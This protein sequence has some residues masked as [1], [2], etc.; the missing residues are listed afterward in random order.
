MLNEC[1][2]EFKD[3]NI[4]NDYSEDELFELFCGI[5]VTKESDT[6]FSEVESAIV[7]GG[8]DGGIDTFAI[9]VNDRIIANEDD[10]S[11][12]K[13]NEKT[14]VSITIIQSKTT[15]SFSESVLDKLYITLPLVFDLNIDESKLLERLNPSVVEKIIA[16]RQVWFSSIKKRSSISFVFCYACKAEIIVINDAFKSK[17]KQ[18]LDL[19]H[20]K[21]SVATADFKLL[22]SKELIELYNYKK[23]AEIELRFK[24]GPLPIP[25]IGKD[26]GYVGAVSLKDFHEFITSERG[27]IREEIFE[28]NIRYYQGEVDVNK[29]IAQTLIEDNVNDFWW[30]NNGIT[31]LCD[32]AQS[33]PKILQITNPQVV[34][35]LQ[36]SFSIFNNKD[37][38]EN[39][40]KKSVLV[41]IILSKERET[42]DK[43]IEATNS[44]NQVP[45]VLLRAT[46]DIQRM[47]EKYFS[48]EEYYYDRRKNYYKNQGKPITRVFT[49]QD[50]AQ[51]I[52]AILNKNP[53]T[54]RKNPTTIIKSDESY[55]RIFSDSYDF[56]LFLN[57]ALIVRSVKLYISALND[58]EIDKNLMKN[59]SFHISL[60]LAS[61]K[62]GKGLFGEDD[63]TQFDKE[64][65][66]E[67]IDK[68][69]KRFLKYFDSYQS[70]MKENPINIAKSSMFDK[71]LIQCIKQDTY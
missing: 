47:I 69:L 29:K 39:S 44:Q 20:E 36:T 22:S 30:L 42:V 11:E 10:V 51:A 50:V 64:N 45:A 1:L 66:P 13:F 43:I 59:F 4:L 8:L 3:Q 46:D 57:A 33:L 37:R 63:I 24:E 71:E 26:Y 28:N 53:S 68:A 41:K 14:K 25:Y 32:T 61:L 55:G 56:K 6:D 58:A 17:Q 67:I 12:I 21:I 27:L 18:I 62:A 31:I 65:N 40:D 15:S 19:I 16:F 7:D 48:T 23:P 70:K 52:E 54:A 38:I 9:L 2:K 60:V 35:G 34:N 5:E 49:I